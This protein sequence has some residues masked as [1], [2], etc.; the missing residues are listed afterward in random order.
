MGW[1]VRMFAPYPQKKD[2]IMIS[3]LVLTHQKTCSIGY[4][5][6]CEETYHLFLGLVP[7]PYLKI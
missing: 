1:G 4:L 7:W 2:L 5:Y 6:C 3:Y